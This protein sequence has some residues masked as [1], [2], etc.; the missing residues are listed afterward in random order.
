MNIKNWIQGKPELRENEYTD[1]LINY[2][3]ASAQ[4]AVVQ[5]LTAG[6]EIAAGWWGRA[7]SSAEIEPSWLHR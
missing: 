1:I 6:V 2:A 4:G 5:G 7:F 3:L